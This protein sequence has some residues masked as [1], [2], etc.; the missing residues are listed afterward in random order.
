MNKIHVIS[1]AK[2][3]H[4][5]YKC[6]FCKLY[7]LTIEY[8]QSRDALFKLQ[9][10]LQLQC[11]N[12]FFACYW[13][14]MK[15]SR[16]METLIFLIAIVIDQATHDCAI[17]KFAWCSGWIIVASKWKK[18]VVAI[19][20]CVIKIGEKYKPYLYLPFFLSEQTVEM[21]VN[22]EDFSF[23]LSFFDDDIRKMRKTVIINNIFRVFIACRRRLFACS[24][25]Q[26]NTDY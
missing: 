7:S 14:A 10:V 21:T 13:I 19:K 26:T 25:I 4:N 16:A 9:V 5:C 22:K 6:K 1:M 15:I 12:G 11:N 17:L 18:F 24:E 3:R 20:M 2:L 23:F 8:F